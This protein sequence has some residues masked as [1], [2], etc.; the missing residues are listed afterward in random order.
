[1]WFEAA[2]CFPLLM[3]SLLFWI[4][5]TIMTVLFL[6]KAFSFLQQISMRVPR[7][8]FSSVQKSPVAILVKVE[9]KPDRLTEFLSVIKEDAVKS[10]TEENGGCLRFDVLNSGSAP[11]KFIFY[12]VYKDIDAMNYHRTTTH[13]KKWADFKNTGPI[14]SQEVE[15]LDNLVSFN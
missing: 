10:R 13:Y 7:K 4:K 1:M 2:E 3:L 6:P 8:F 15:L 12:E 11:N 5:I 9:I 14:V